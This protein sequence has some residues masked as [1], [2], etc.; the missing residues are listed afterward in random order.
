ML[1]SLDPETST[2]CSDIYSYLF[3]PDA[4]LKE[5][6][7]DDPAVSEE[8]S[9]F[10]SASIAEDLSE[11]ELDAPFCFGSN[12]LNS[13]GLESSDAQTCYGDSD[14][15][16]KL[17]NFELERKELITSRN[18]TD[19]YVH[20][21]LSTNLSASKAMKVKRELKKNSD[22]LSS[23]S[24]LRLYSN[25]SGHLYGHINHVG[26]RIV[27]QHLRTRSR[28]REEFHRRSKKSP[29]SRIGRSEVER[30]QENEKERERRRE[31]REQINL[32]ATL[33]P[34]PYR[35]QSNSQKECRLDSLQNV[36]RFLSHIYRLLS[37][38]EELNKLDS[39][40]CALPF[41]SA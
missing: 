37:W 5:E 19:R 31:L 28:P 26:Q 22:Y 29:V 7:S 9:K 32:V 39:D 40:L 16:F 23:S 38:N 3:T 1:P 2:D 10:A 15:D 13:D 4:E 8:D 36:E 11:V 33:V 30:A 20:K 27:P 6:L 18:Y 41:N 14:S 17:D 21:N 35:Q 24:Q 12:F 34:L 25:G